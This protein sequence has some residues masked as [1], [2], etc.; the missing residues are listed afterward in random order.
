MSEMEAEQGSTWLAH[1]QLGQDMSILQINMRDL[2][3]KK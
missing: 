1:L 3:M 2:G